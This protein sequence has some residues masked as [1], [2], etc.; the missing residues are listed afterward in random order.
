METTHQAARGRDDEGPALAKLVALTN[1]F[2]AGDDYVIAGGGNTSWKSQTA[3]Y[4]KGS[5]QAM[6]DIGPG[7]FVR[8]ERS[9]LAAV[10]RRAYPADQG[11]REKLV[12]E[13]LLAAK[14][15]GQD[16]KRPS[17]E[18]LLHD[19]LPFAYVVHTHPSLVNGITCGK[20]G[21]LAFEKLFGD[22]GIWI[23]LV[24]PGYVL[25]QAVKDAVE[26]F[27]ARH[28]RAPRLIFMENHGIV[29][30]G[31]DPESIQT[32]YGLIFD[33]IRS[34]G[35]AEPQFD[36]SPLGSLADV[37][38][39]SA[40]QGLARE[41]LERESKSSDRVH[42]QRETGKTVMGLSSD[43]VEFATIGS[44][45]TP[46]HIVYM[47]VAPIRVDGPG[48]LGAAWQG[49][50]AAYGK[51]PRVVLAKGLGA[52]CLG[53]GEK[54]AERTLKI[55][56]DSVRISMASRSFGGPKFMEKE[57]IDFIRSWEVES[58]RSQVGGGT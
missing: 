41:D 40:L 3:L 31:E 13:D 8:M 9:A 4:I 19:L 10:W 11:E 21:R 44:A 36:G 30:S 52:F 20:D 29:V 25:S 26:T 54:A 14:S 56:R 1:R 33:R 37:A 48:D 6:A 42:V 53:S 12:L 24:N 2:G 7:G 34:L 45:F 28:G 47:G 18:T 15:K 17:V 39:L 50:A 43:D 49:Y 55:F 35:I 38:F 58:Y 23:P 32:G 57:F 16:G 46:D 22:E 51:A 27:S 5:G